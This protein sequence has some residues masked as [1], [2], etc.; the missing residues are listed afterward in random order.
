M[1][2]IGSKES[3]QECSR[4]PCLSARLFQRPSGPAE[5]SRLSEGLQIAIW[6]R[7][8]KATGHSAGHS[9]ALMSSR[10]VSQ[11]SCISLRTLLWNLESPSVF[12]RVDAGCE[13]RPGFKVYEQ[14][15]QIASSETLQLT[16]GRATEDGRTAAHREGRE[17]AGS[18]ARSFPKRWRPGVSSSPHSSETG[19]DAPP[20][21]GRSGRRGPGGGGAR[22]AGERRSQRGR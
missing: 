15:L 6:T 9:R 14:S 10:K 3:L 20:R 22:A 16:R 21:G 7:G 8:R 18:L 1:R 13:K 5:A 19:C 17:G 4:R 12:A 11:T 2:V